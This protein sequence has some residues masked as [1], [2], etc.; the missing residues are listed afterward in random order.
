MFVDEA[1]I[2]V[3]SGKGGNGTVSFRREKYVPRGGPDGGDGGRGGS[4]FMVAR[5]AINTLMAF[6]YQRHFEAQNGEAGSGRQKT[7][8]R[9]EDLY[10]EVP[11]GTVIIDADTEEFIADLTILDAPLE[12][13]R[14]G[15]YG[16][17][18]IHFKSSTNQ[19]PRTA[20]KGTEGET[21]R[22]K[23]ELKVM[24]DVG[25]LGLPNA[26]KSSLLRRLSH[27]TPKVADY[28]FTTLE[29]HLGMVSV[30]PG[31]AF[32]M[33]D[34]PGIIEG[35]SEGIGL[36]IRFLKHVQRT[37]L[38]LHMVDCLPAE[39]TS[40][41]AQVAVIENEIGSFGHNLNRKQRWLVVNKVDLLTPEQLSELK[42][43][44]KPIKQPVFL[45]STINGEGLPELKQALKQAIYGEDDA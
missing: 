27:A 12:V 36:G 23:L 18:N 10:I 4:V 45:V 9:G 20:T 40:V 2:L 26:G 24:A 11:K 21:R 6:R 35:A 37:Q 14:G 28:P 33:A 3:V 7:G 8:K 41:Q 32:V 1:E 25:L 43:T 42:V 5:E 39:Q 30:Q 13:V 29:P 34:I 31:E 44:L 16:L 19:A 22:L 38:L 17:G 15:Q